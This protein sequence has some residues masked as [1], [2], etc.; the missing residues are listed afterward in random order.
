[1]ILVGIGANLPS[2]RFGDPM[3]T[4]EAACDALERLDFV[5]IIARSGWFESAP[6]PL[7]DQPWFINGVVQVDTKLPPNELLGALHSIEA[8][9]GRV[10]SERN[11]PR[12][13]DLDLLAYDDIKITDSSPQ[14]P[15]PRMHVRAFVLLPLAKINP[16]WVHPQNGAKLADLIEKLPKDQLCRP[17]K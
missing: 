17:L 15:H 14:I 4:C 3:D 13:L 10:R 8:D 16:D 5:H 2:D 1:M 9:F 7:S 12:V 11:A 6:V